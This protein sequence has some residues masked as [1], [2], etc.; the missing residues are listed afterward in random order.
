[1]CTSSDYIMRKDLLTEYVWHRPGDKIWVYGG[2]CYIYLQFKVNI[3]VPKKRAHLQLHTADPSNHSHICV[4]CVRWINSSNFYTLPYSPNVPPLISDIRALWRSALRQSARMSEIKN[5]TL[6]LYGAEHSKCNH[7]M[8]SGFK[9][10]IMKWF[11]TTMM[12]SN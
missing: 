8:T 11:R 5:G 9:R 12:K 7:M 1:M 4:S 10:I 6:G 2:S 3:S